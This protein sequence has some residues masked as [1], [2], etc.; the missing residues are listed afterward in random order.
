MSDLHIDRVLTHGE[1]AG[2]DHFEASF[3]A[4]IRLCIPDDQRHHA[5]DL[6]RWA[7]EM[8]HG[9]ALP[10]VGDVLYLSSTSA[11]GVSL[12][13]HERL[14]PQVTRVEI[15]LEHVGAARHTRDPGSRL[16]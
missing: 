14:S 11:W 10:R 1:L 12:V 9:T 8:P 15:W 3:P 7:L 2:L 16:Q 4:P 6:P 5:A 13:I